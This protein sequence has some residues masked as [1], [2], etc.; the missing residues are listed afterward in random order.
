MIASQGYFTPYDLTYV[1][2]AKH[3]EVSL[4]DKKAVWIDGYLS[5]DVPNAEESPDQNPTAKWVSGR[6]SLG[7]K[8]GGLVS[9]RLISE[10][11][12]LHELVKIAE[13]FQ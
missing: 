6:L 4:G 8:E 13:S 10:G 9:I 11:L 1:P 5:V 2:T 7:W 3:G 12:S